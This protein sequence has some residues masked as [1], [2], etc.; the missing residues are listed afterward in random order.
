MW[1]TTVC[2]IAVALLLCLYGT[3]NAHECAYRL[4][5]VVKMHSGAVECAC[6][7]SSS[8][9]CAYTKATNTKNN[10]T[11]LVSIIRKRLRKE[12]WLHASHSVAYIHVRAGDGIVGPNCFRNTSDCRVSASTG[13]QYARGKAYFDSLGIPHMPLVVHASTRHHTVDNRGRPHQ[14][15]YITDVLTYL[16]AYGPVVPKIN[17]PVDDTFIELATACHLFIT[18][19]GFGQL[20]HDLT[21]HFCRPN[22]LGQLGK[23]VSHRGHFRV[24][25][26]NKRKAGKINKKMAKRLAMQQN[27][28]GSLS[29][30]RGPSAGTASVAFTPIQGLEIVIKEKKVAEAN[31]KY[32]GTN[33]FQ[34]VKK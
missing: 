23:N 8:I 16:S 9:G 18:G 2:F 27:R 17:I 11:V 25:E 29:S 4:G 1:I 31:A 22:S 12:P 26:T 13:K 14:K 19:G 20:A 7:D 32:F 24:Q 34:H 21:H 33:I 5:D 10:L 30:I 3:W 6:E 28:S 15:H